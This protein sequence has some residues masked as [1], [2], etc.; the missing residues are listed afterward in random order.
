MIRIQLEEAVKIIEENSYK[1][2]DIEEVYLEEAL[3]RVCAKD[4]YSPIFN[5]PFDK[6]PLDGYALIAKDTKGASRENPVKLKV[7]DE[8][9]AGSYSKVN[10]K[11]GEAVR[12][13]TGA[14]LPEGC[15]A[16][17]RQEDTDEGMDTVEI[18]SELKD[19]SNYCFCGEDIR[20]MIF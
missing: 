19:L 18:Y 11:E 5:P 13:M 17:I 15:N 4:V 14:K 2:E 1:I 3:G 20:K 16:V 7:V 6:S 8:V 12:I 10:L 9:F